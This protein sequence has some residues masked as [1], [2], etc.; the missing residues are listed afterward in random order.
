MIHTI[1]SPILFY[2]NHTDPALE[3]ELAHFE[4]TELRLYWLIF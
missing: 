1:K 4:Q 3:H 2:S